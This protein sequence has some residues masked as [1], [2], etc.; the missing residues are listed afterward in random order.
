MIITKRLS[1]YYINVIIVLGELMKKIFEDRSKLM[2]CLTIVEIILALWILIAFNYS[3]RLSYSEAMEYN[4]DNLSLLLESMYTST[5]YALIILTANLISIFSLVSTIFKKQE[6]HF[7]SIS[8]WCVL[9]ILAVDLN[10]S[11]MSNAAT[12]AIFIPIILLNIVA[13][14][15]QKKILNKK[16]K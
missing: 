3:D 4:Q 16:T 10:I 5:W 7:V 14:F 12:L 9:M 6:F 13:F 8:L 2:I 1:F 15:N 11:F